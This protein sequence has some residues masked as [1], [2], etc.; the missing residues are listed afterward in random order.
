MCHDRRTALAN[1]TLHGNLTVTDYSNLTSSHGPLAGEPFEAPR[2][3]LY[4]HL[5]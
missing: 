3:R 1:V 2:E 5:T 4:V